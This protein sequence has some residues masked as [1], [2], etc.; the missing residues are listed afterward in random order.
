[1]AAINS[2]KLR[3]ML[4]DHVAFDQLTIMV[5]K[6][7]PMLQ[8]AANK[9]IKVSD[10]AGNISDAVKE[11]IIAA[12]SNGGVFEQADFEGLVDRLGLRPQENSRDMSY[13][14]RR[15]S[16]QSRLAQRF[17]EITRDSG[18][19]FQ[20]MQGRREEYMGQLYGQLQKEIRTANHTGGEKKK[21]E[22]YLTRVFNS[23]TKD[24]GLESS[25]SYTARQAGDWYSGPTERFNLMANEIARRAIEQTPKTA[26]TT[27]DVAIATNKL[28]EMIENARYKLIK[29]GKADVRIQRWQDFQWASVTDMNT[30]FSVGGNIK[31]K[32]VD[33]C[34]LVTA[35]A[36]SL[37]EGESLAVNTL[38][39]Q[40]DSDA[41]KQYVFGRD[42]IVK[43]CVKT[44]VA[45]RVEGA[46]RIMRPMTNNPYLETTSSKRVAVKANYGIDPKFMIQLR[47]EIMTQLL[48]NHVEA[49]VNAKGA[50]ITI[51]DLAA[52]FSDPVG[53]DLLDAAIAKSLADRVDKLEKLDGHWFGAYFSQGWAK[54]FG[55]KSAALATAVATSAIES[56][57]AF[58]PLNAVSVQNAIA[59]KTEAKKLIA[60]KSLAFETAA[61]SVDFLII[62]EMRNTRNHPEFDLQS[63]V[64]KHLIEFLVTNPNVDQK[65]FTK[66]LCD[67][68]EERVKV[69]KT[70][71]FAHFYEKGNRSTGWLAWPGVVLSKA[72]L[73]IKKKF[74]GRAGGIG[75]NPAGFEAV[76]RHAREVALT[77]KQPDRTYNMH[78]DAAVALDRA[79]EN[80]NETAKGGKITI[81]GKQYDLI[82]LDSKVRATL[83]QQ[84]INQL[85]KARVDGKRISL[86][87]IVSSLE[88]GMKELVLRDRDTRGVITANSIVKSL[89]DVVAVAPHEKPLPRKETALA[90]V[91]KLV[92]NASTNNDA[93]GVLSLSNLATTAKEA[94]AY[95]M[96]EVPKNCPSKVRAEIAKNVKDALQTSNHT[97]ITLEFLDSLKASVLASLVHVE[98]EMGTKTINGKTSPV[99]LVA[100]SW[101]INAAETAKMSTVVAQHADKVSTE[102]EERVAKKYQVDLDAVRNGR[103][104]PNTRATVVAGEQGVESFRVGREATQDP[105]ALLPRLHSAVALVQFIANHGKSANPEHIIL[106]DEML[107]DPQNADI[108]LDGKFN[109]V[110]LAEFFRHHPE[111]GVTAEINKRIVARMDELGAAMKA[112]PGST[113][114]EV[115]KTLQ[116][117]K[118][119]TIQGTGGLV[120]NKATINALATELK[121]TLEGLAANPLFPI[122][123]DVKRKLIVLQQ[124]LT[125]S[126]LTEVTEA[127]SRQVHGANLGGWIRAGWGV[128]SSATG[129]HTL[130]DVVNTYYLTTTAD[131][132]E[133]R[134]DLP[135]GFTRT[136]APA[137]TAQSV[138]PRLLLE[139]HAK[140]ADVIHFNLRPVLV[141][142]GDHVQ[143][144]NVGELLLM[145]DNYRDHADLSKKIHDFVKKTPQLTN[146][147]G[148]MVNNLGLDEFLVKQGI[149]GGVTGA[150]RDTESLIKAAADQKAAAI[151]AAKIVELTKKA[152]A[153]GPARLAEQQLRQFGHGIDGAPLKPL[154]TPSR[155]NANSGGIVR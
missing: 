19:D 57:M 123:P 144:K 38:A 125:G 8:S 74:S 52:K 92:I 32:M 72:W 155:G 120:A 135:A 91:C 68:I 61:R 77:G 24:P 86:D 80:F 150:I 151:Q 94:V 10:G 79:I 84:I 117:V 15:T 148:V 45:S 137:T 64:R 9:D 3:E 140:R 18:Y 104:L 106:I 128:V 17:Y 42:L 41:G 116:S 23:S 30:A 81:S 139:V 153:L 75:A 73:A 63:N 25:L 13:L 134:G 109:R 14:D 49:T 56:F 113:V 115:A 76:L 12:V 7:H 108:I 62:D 4:Q 78:R 21:L 36:K 112:C 53:Q 34:P 88:A 121:P 114:V 59:L 143:R 46:G 66:A 149:V 67:K 142:A 43:D 31:I 22:E 126:N 35:M 65:A 145:I 118:G 39:T 96:S 97:P 33:E 103:A 89:A 133:L 48:K 1:M 71:K 136:P 54:T 154:G 130:K 85:E 16:I 44:F 60:D 70:F 51:E 40:L 5:N 124:A 27:A 152:G 6:I 93:L 29:R 28:A 122:A 127:A 69:N 111:L 98:Q 110:N 107:N 147:S 82:S 2:Q 58:D 87:H 146:R 37:L 105:E 129:S 11:G 119:A 20:D 50:K 95:A 102:K 101:G 100:E 26:T 55:L 138:D 141:E 47:K 131:D 132:K 90:D 99:I 83:E